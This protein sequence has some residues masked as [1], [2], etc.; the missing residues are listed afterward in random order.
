[1]PTTITSKSN[2]PTPTATQ[3]YWLEHIQSQ[4]LSGLSMAAYAKSQ[5]IAVHNFYYWAQQLRE[6]QQSNELTPAPLF[7]PV[8]LVSTQ[9][10]PQ[11]NQLTVVFRFP[12]RIEC[13]LLHA[14][15]QTCVEVIQS[16]ARVTL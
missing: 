5:G 6:R 12:N 4:Q 15:L 7:Q 3:Q 16:L 2:A 8:T 10:R 11:S 9:S 13:E 14:D 1:M